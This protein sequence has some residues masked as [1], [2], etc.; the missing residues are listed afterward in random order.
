MDAPR[1]FVGLQREEWA[2]SAWIPMFLP[3]SLTSLD[4]RTRAW[5][6]CAFALAQYFFRQALEQKVG[7]S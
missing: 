7:G 4:P 1:E 6:V 5:P 2:E 3:G